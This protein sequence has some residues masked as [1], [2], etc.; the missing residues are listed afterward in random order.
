[1]R[2]NARE[3]D[4][5]AR[6]LAVGG[7]AYQLVAVPVKAP[8]RIAWLVMGFH[9]DDALARRFRDL[10]GREISFVSGGEVP[11]VVGST[12]PPAARRQ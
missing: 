10:T 6:T 9:V 3:H 5:D 12:L 4:I 7:R 11:A 1:M 8:Q 2:Q